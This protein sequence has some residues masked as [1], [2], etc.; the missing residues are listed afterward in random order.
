MVKVMKFSAAWCGPCKALKP[1]FEEVKTNFSN[2]VF[3]DVDVDEQFE[4]A[5]K[6][7]IRS[8]PTVVVERDGTEIERFSGVQSKMA[9]VNAINESLK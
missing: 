8:V 9:Y 7:G 5:G 2:V 4:L 1:M 6:Y 3:E